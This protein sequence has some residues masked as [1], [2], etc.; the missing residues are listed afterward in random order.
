VEAYNESGKK[1]TRGA[2][3]LFSQ[4]IQHEIDHLDGIL[5]T[6]KALALKRIL[7]QNNQSQN[8]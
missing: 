8:V 7:P 5:F 4:V 2:S 1:F 6:D 3:G